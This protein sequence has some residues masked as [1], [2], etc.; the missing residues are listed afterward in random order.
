MWRDSEEWGRSYAMVMT[1][2]VGVAAQ[3]HARMP[4]ILEGDARAAWVDAKPAEA[5]ALCVG[6]DG[7]VAIDRTD[8]PWSGGAAQRRLL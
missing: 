3:V 8:Q 5:I 7:P 4:V 6:Y 1:D 2:A